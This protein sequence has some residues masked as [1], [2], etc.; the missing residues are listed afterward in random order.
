MADTMQ[1]YETLC[2]VVSSALG[3]K[4]DSPPTQ[5]DPRT[6]PRTYDELEARLQRVLG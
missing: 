3:G 4:K 2:I 5:V 1:T 6:A